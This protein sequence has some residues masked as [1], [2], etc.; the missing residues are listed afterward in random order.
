MIQGGDP[1]G[2]G[3]GGPGYTI[4]DEFTDSNTNDRGTIAMANAGPNSGGSQFFL[5]TADNNFLDD[6]H[7]SFGTIVEGMD[8]VD[9]ISKV[10]KNAQ[11]KPLE[12]V[13]ILEA[14]IL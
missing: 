11:D 8:V 1:L 10:P 4:E 6:K 5:N 12:D 9:A 14:T 13:V 7:P 2:T 3:T